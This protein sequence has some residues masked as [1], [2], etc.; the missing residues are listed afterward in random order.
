MVVEGVLRP[1]DDEQHAD[2]GERRRRELL[3]QPLGVH[4]TDAMRFGRVV[5]GLALAEHAGSSFLL[6]P[7]ADDFHVRRVGSCP[8]CRLQDLGLIVIASHDHRAA[9]AA[10]PGWC[11]LMASTSGRSGRR[12]PDKETHEQW[13]R[14]NRRLR[15]RRRFTRRWSGTSRWSG[16]GSGGP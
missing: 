6:A 3:D 8:A 1:A 10:P 7:G 15:W 11:Y 2:P 13:S 14:S 9:I 12:R 16:A 5:E 4:G